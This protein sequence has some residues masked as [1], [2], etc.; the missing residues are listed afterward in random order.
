VEFVEANL[1][2]ICAIV[3]TRQPGTWRLTDRGTQPS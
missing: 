2:P 1:A 3:S